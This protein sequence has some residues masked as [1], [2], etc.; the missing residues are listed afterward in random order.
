MVFIEYLHSNWVGIVVDVKVGLLLGYLTALF[1]KENPTKIHPQTFRHQVYHIREIVYINR[2]PRSNRKKKS[3]RGSNDDFRIYLFA[4]VLI[5]MLFIEYKTVIF[6]FILSSL[7][8]TTSGV[9][10]FTSYLAKHKLLKGLNLYYIFVLA[11]I[12]TASYIMFYNLG[13]FDVKAY[14]GLTQLL[15]DIGVKEL[16]IVITKV[17]GYL[18]GI[19]AIL[20]I[21]IIVLHIWLSHSQ[22]LLT[23]RFLQLI[24]R[25]TAF[26]TTKDKAFIP[27]LIVLCFTSWFFSSG[28][29]GKMFYNLIGK[30]D[31]VLFGVR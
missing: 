11:L 5:T 25:K 15:S 9:V 14:G 29:Y 23:S 10:A 26:V 2:S 31:N 12:L 1:Q 3:N 6:H 21:P 13:G 4:S 28:T 24:F 27:Y 22:F 18:L 30:L 19:L 20:L 7:I 17:I 16:A 8:I